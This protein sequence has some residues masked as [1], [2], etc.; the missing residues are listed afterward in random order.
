M[1]KTLAIA[2]GS[3][4]L[5]S[6]VAYA[7]PDSVLSAPCTTCHKGIPPSKENLNPMAAA[8]LATH[9][10]VAKCKE[11]HTKGANDKLA[12]NARTK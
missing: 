12:T 8:M 1:S 2:I 6:G 7:T 4:I 11:C 9:K 3:A 5:V 10:D